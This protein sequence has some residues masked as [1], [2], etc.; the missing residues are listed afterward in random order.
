MPISKTLFGI[1]K[2]NLK[3]IKFQRK[4]RHQKILNFSWIIFTDS[5]MS[6]ENK[7]MKLM[8]DS[9]EQIFKMLKKHIF[10][11]VKM[12]FRESEINFKNKLSKILIRFFRKF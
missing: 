3:L 11:N 1:K 12:F 8:Q 2:I 7:K 4:I 6:L 10:N 9:F 5:L